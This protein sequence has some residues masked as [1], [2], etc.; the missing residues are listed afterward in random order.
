MDVPESYSSSIYAQLSNLYRSSTLKE[1]IWRLIF[2]PEQPYQESTDFVERYPDQV[3][4][5]YQPLVGEMKH[6]TEYLEDP[7]VDLEEVLYNIIHKIETLCG[8][9][10]HFMKYMTLQQYKKLVNRVLSLEEMNNGKM[11]ILWYF[12]ILLQKKFKNMKAQEMMKYFKEKIST[13]TLQ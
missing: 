13:L 7:E 8:R 11:L 3:F 9:H 4:L 12:T 1:L 2:Y 6:C 5:F 10:Y